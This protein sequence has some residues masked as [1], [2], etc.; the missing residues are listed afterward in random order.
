MIQGLR[1]THMMLLIIA[2]TV[3]SRAPPDTCQSMK[4]RLMRN[5]QEKASKMF[6]PSSTESQ[7]R[8]LSCEEIDQNDLNDAEFKNC[9]A[10]IL[11]QGENIELNEDPQ[12]SECFS[13]FWKEADRDADSK[14]SSA[15]F[16]NWK[17]IGVLNLLLSASELDD[18]IVENETLNTKNR[19]M[20]KEEQQNVASG[21][22][23]QIGDVEFELNGRQAESL[24]A[25]TAAL[26]DGNPLEAFVQLYRLLAI[27]FI[28]G[29]HTNILIPLSDIMQTMVERTIPR[30]RSQAM[31]I[32]AGI[33]FGGEQIISTAS[34]QTVSALS[35]LIR[36]TVDNNPPDIA[37]QIYDT[38]A[39]LISDLTPIRRGTVEQVVILL[40]SLAAPGTSSSSTSQ[41]VLVALSALLSNISISDATRTSVLSLAQAIVSESPDEV[42]N[43]ISSVFNDVLGS[44]STLGNLAAESLISIVRALAEGDRQEAVMQTSHLQ[45]LVSR[46]TGVCQNEYVVTSL[47]PNRE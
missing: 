18:Q 2:G 40:R 10:Q 24:S 36:A 3:V 15:E 4:K 21:V 30:V 32:L 17:K 47:S 35:G 33:I 22:K 19:S 27:S 42:L 7:S 16:L 13:E 23:V 37:N 45:G 43:A 26:Q 41:D 6:T 20:K 5:F 25:V 11:Q 31:S 34:R 38:V 28:R 44:V 46:Q 1:V 12:R 14:V 39:G 9:L 8:T 29:F